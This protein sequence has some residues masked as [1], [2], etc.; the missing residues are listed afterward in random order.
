MSIQ[1]R[2]AALVLFGLTAAPGLSAASAVDAQIA[3]DR[4][5]ALSAIH[6]DVAQDLSQQLRQQM[7]LCKLD[8]MPPTPEAVEVAAVVRDSATAQCT[9]PT[10]S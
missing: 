2:I 4:T 8:L 5:R 3:E 6:A 9:T 10:Q 7:L 1:N